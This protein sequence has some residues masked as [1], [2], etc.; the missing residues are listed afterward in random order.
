METEIKKE[1]LGLPRK[2]T[3]KQELIAMEVACICAKESNDPSTQVGSCIVSNDNRIIS[4]GYNHNPSMWSTET[5]PW[6][7]DISV[8]GE[9]NT[10]YPYIIHSEMDAISKCHNPN[11]LKGG[12]IYVTL[13]PCVQCAKTIVAFGIKKVVYI[14]YRDSIEATCAKRLLE[15]CGIEIVNYNDILNDNKILDESENIKKLKL[16]IKRGK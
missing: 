12:T 10:K 13:F 4:T 7:N 3:L 11:E 6:R 16:N 15:K 1:Y 14:E 9:E 8:I 5:F 2:N